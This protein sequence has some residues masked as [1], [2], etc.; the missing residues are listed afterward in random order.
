M[1][2]KPTADILPDS[3]T[4]VARGLVWSSAWGCMAVPIYCAHC[5]RAGGFVPEA[6]CDFAFWLCDPCF[7][8]HG[9]I[10]GTFVTPDEAFFAR[11]AAEEGYLDSADAAF[12]AP[13]APLSPHRS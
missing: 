3:R 7:A 9:H 11:I 8:H 12:P 1:I 4:K 5:G 13:P 6:N 2:H 10:T